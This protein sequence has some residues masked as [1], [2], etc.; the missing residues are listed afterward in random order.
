[1]RRLITTIALSLAALALPASAAAAPAYEPNDGIHQ[2]FGPLAAGTNYD[3]A[4]TSNNDEDWYVLYVSGQGVLDVALTNTDDASGG[5]THVDL[6]D[7]DGTSLNSESYISE[8]TTEHLVYTTPGPGQYYVVIDSDSA[9][10]QYR[11][12]VSGP[13]T[14][15]PRPGPAAATP[16]TNP[17]LTTA[18]GPLLG[19]TLYGGSID[20]YDEEDW[21]YFYTAGPGAFDISLTNIADDSGG[22]VHGYL[23]DK[24]T[25]QLNGES[26][27]SEN[28]IAHLTYTAA[29]PA[30]F[31]LEISSDSAGDHYQ[32][33][34]DPG[35]MLT[36]VEPPSVSAAC[37]RATAKLDRKKA[38]LAKA[39]EA[40]RAALTPKAKKKAKK[41][42]K[43]AKRKV[44]K[45]KKQVKASC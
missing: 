23:Y 44:K 25:N 5:S 11:L 24:D 42:V 45:A 10:D 43:K 17:D 37:E 21:F 6:L 28:R 18:F 7:K 12:T 33:R 36:T 15:G 29:G 13:L 14:T 4:I 3:A 32:F 9:G 27:I 31:A 39:K 38:K 22:S 26:Y 35:S 40:R 1:M 34:I 2:A 19:D 30:K 8:N 20:A 16:N 41:K